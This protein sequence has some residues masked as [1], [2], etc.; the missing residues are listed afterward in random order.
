MPLHFFLCLYLFQF[1]AAYP[2]ICVNSALSSPVSSSANL[3]LMAPP[4]VA[5]SNTIL[6][7]NNGVGVNI[8]NNNSK[9]DSSVGGGN[10][11]NSESMSEKSSGQAGEQEA[12]QLIREKKL[13]TVWEDQ[14][15]DWMNSMSLKS[16][17][18]NSPE[19]EGEMGLRAKSIEK[20]L[21]TVWKKCC[22][23]IG[24]I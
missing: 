17:S 9:H 23:I 12:K 3:V 18:R 7:N 16:T 6:R 15:C 24:W 22:H 8:N 10:S 5:N 11:S 14:P 1:P 19:Q 2:K 4:A 21:Q 20:K 13:K